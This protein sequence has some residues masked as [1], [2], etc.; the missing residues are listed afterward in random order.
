MSSRGEANNELS[1]SV[2]KS[3]RLIENGI[4]YL[5]GLYVRSILLYRN[6]IY[7]IRG[8]FCK[9]M[10]DYHLKLR[11]QSLKG[12]LPGN[13]LLALPLGVFTSSSSSLSSPSEPTK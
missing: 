6:E 1:P 2:P 3:Y 13:L 5:V 12:D 9:G 8:W 4:P 11:L 7:K 10:N